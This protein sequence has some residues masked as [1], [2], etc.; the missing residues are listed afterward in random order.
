MTR[1]RK[2]CATLTKGAP[3]GQLFD[4][5][6]RRP[7]KRVQNGAK[8]TAEFPLF[9]CISLSGFVPRP[10]RNCASN[11]RVGSSSLSGRASF[12]TKTRFSEFPPQL[13]RFGVLP[14]HRQQDKPVFLGGSHPPKKKAGGGGAVIVR[15]P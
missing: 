1:F 10:G 4:F 11:Q 13:V 7:Y 8:E 15:I 9:C 6:P 14:V 2:T 5:C 3:Q 12:L